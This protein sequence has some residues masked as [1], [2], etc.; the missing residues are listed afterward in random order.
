MET[1]SRKVSNPS[2]LN[3]CLSLHLGFSESRKDFQLSIF[4][5]LQG[6]R[7][8]IFPNLPEVQS[9]C[10]HLTEIDFPHQPRFIHSSEPLDSSHGRLIEER[11]RR[12]LWFGCLVCG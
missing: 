1:A 12:N 10:R 5:H 7:H 6:H 3:G 9:T 4:E 8:I 2:F 11:K